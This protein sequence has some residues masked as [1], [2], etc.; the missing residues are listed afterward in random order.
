MS[1]KYK[2]AY[3]ELRK[4]FIKLK[5][6]YTIV[7]NKNK[8]LEFQHSS[9]KN[10]CAKMYES[11]LNLKDEY[12]K[13]IDE[14]DDLRSQLYA[15]RGELASTRQAIDKQRKEFV[16]F[17]APIATPSPKTRRIRFKNQNLQRRESRRFSGNKK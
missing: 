5:E 15:T 12:N 7:Y 6:A 4:D 2:K 11:C 13:I 14:N 9:D 1:E 16:K 17:Q 8:A 10:N 3:D